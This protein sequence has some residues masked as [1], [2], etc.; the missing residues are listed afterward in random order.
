MEL[1]TTTKKNLLVLREKDFLINENV[2]KRISKN[3]NKENQNKIIEKSKEIIKEQKEIIKKANENKKTKYPIKTY[4]EYLNK[5]QQ[6]AKELNVNIKFIDSKKDK[7][8]FKKWN[9]I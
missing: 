8:D 2:F 5:Q 4:L 7:E 9:L 3:R 1:Q 6:I